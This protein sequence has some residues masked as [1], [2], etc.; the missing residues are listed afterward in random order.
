MWRLKHIA[1]SQ[2]I[3]VIALMAI[4]C[5]RSPEAP[6]A[7]NRVGESTK[8]VVSLSPAL[9]QIIVQ[10]GQG[11]L[12]VGVAQYDEVAAQGLPIVGHWQ[13]INTET[14]LSVQPTHV[15]TMSGKGA[16]PPRHLTKLA[17]SCG[18]RVVS[19]PSPN[20][21]Q[22]IAKI[23]LNDQELDGSTNRIQAQCL[24][25]LLDAPDAARQMV[26][27]MQQTFDAIR[28][29]TNDAPKHRVLLV[30]G[31]APFMVSGP[32]TFLDQILTL[33]GG[34]NAAGDTLTGAP[35]FDKERL[36]HADPDV[37]LMLLPN[38]PPLGSV[39][40][41]PRL[42][43]LRGL[44]LPAVQ[45]G[46]IVLINDP[47]VHL[48]GSSLARIAVA[49]AKAIHPHLAEKLGANLATDL[50]LASSPSL[51]RPSEQNE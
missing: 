20:N 13:D 30:I 36:I 39:D 50:V 41:D 5:D 51:Q 45:H 27:R 40:T 11:D 6:A 37:I 16:P 34:E 17:I 47:Q 14:L 19:Y 18:F 35:V 7:V 28:R 38:V 42:S 26:A 4:S 9:S 2:L 32:G 23:I 31:V 22:D 15:L 25:L 49:M 44:N 48:P 33:C 8:R 43:L 1:L 12:L 46:R 3:T 24:G 29:V 10:L 21:F